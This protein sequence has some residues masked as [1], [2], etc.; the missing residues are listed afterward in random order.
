MEKKIKLKYIHKW[1]KHVDGVQTPDYRFKQVST[2]HYRRYYNTLCVIA[3]VGGCARNVLDYI[4]ER[5]DNNNIIHSNAQMRNQFI[6]DIS[7]WTEGEIVYTDASVKK[8]LHVLVSKNLLLKGDK[9]GSLQV[10]PEYFFKGAEAERLKTI[11]MILEFKTEKPF[12][13]YE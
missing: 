4:S 12:N 1:I 2:S 9:R 5:M 3:G 13:E 6:E 7:K 10:N 8:A 11:Q